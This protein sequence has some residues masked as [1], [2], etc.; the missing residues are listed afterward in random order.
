VLNPFKHPRTLVSDFTVAEVVLKQFVK[1]ASQASRGGIFRFAPIIVFH[2][3]V[4]PEGG[5]TQI[6]TRAMHELMIASGARKSIIWMG[7]ELSKQE[8]ISQ[9]FGTGGEVLSCHP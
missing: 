4:N 3:L 8:L 2:P 9:K 6:E 1:K 5:F 7:R